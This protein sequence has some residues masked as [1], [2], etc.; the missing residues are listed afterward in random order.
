M[1]KTDECKVCEEPLVRVEKKY[2]SYWRHIKTP[3]GFS[4]HRPWAAKEYD[5][6]EKR[7]KNEFCYE[8][9]PKFMMVFCRREPNHEGNH[10][11]FSGIEWDQTVSY[12]SEQWGL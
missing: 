7:L 6:A 1:S 12:E 9:H 4:P 2:M 11:S 3:V 8:E 10:R 5:E